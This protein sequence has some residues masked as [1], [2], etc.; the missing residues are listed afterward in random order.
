[1]NIK[2]IKAEQVNVI[3]EA[4]NIQ[5]SNKK[6]KEKPSPKKTNFWN[7]GL[8]VLVFYLLILL[9][10]FAFKSLDI[11]LYWFPLVI[12]GTI[13]IFTVSGAFSLRDNEKL[14]QKNF[15]ELMSIVFKKL[16]GIG[17]FTHNNDN[18]KIKD[19]NEKM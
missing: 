1:M 4:N 15:I 19:N 8:L 11:S 17:A 9:S 18:K 14:T 10:I 12:F 6:M 3:N 16:I 7:S 2:K 5:I 13:L